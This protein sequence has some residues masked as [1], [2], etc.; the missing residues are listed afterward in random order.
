MADSSILAQLL[1]SEVAKD[2]GCKVVLTGDGADEH[3]LVIRGIYG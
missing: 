3:F 2:N 1:I